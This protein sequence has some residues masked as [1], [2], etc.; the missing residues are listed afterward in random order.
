MKASMKR[1]AAIGSVLALVVASGCASFD[2]NV[3]YDGNGNGEAAQG[4]QD[5]LHLMHVDSQSGE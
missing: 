1:I 3:A 2:A 4:Q 5:I